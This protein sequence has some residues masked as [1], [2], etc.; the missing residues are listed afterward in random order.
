MVPKLEDEEGFATA[1][2]VPA[3]CWGASELVIGA[4]EAGSEEVTAADEAIA[5]DEVGVEVGVGVLTEDVDT[6][7]IAAEV[8]GMNVLDEVKVE[9][10]VDT[11]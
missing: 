7:L 9:V 10:I 11:P 2:A 1:A 5:E 6:L 4:D 8:S 3:D